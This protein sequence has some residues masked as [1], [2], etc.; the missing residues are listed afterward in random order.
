MQSKPE[1]TTV[2]RLEMASKRLQLYDRTGP[3]WLGQEV[4]GSG[5]CNPFRQHS[6]QR[7]WSASSLLTHGF[8]FGG[9][10]PEEGRFVDEL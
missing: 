8:Q 7:D 2:L 4:S 3:Q 9:E 1:P 10:V 5:S 6:H